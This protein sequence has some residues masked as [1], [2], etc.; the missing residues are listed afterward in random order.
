MSY[1]ELMNAL[2]SKKPQFTNFSLKDVK[3]VA[4]ALGN[5]ERS[6]PCV[7][8][9]GTNGKGSV[10]LKVAR[11][12]EMSGLKVGLFTSPHLFSYRERIEINRVM[13]TEEEII[14]RLVYLMS[15][16]EE[17][18]PS[19]SFFDISTFLAFS[20]FKEQK[21]DIA[22]IEAG[23]GGKVDTTNIITPLVSVIT[24][25]GNDHKDVLGGSIEQIAAHKAGIIKPSVPVVIG[26]FADFRV[27][28][29]AAK[30]NKSYVHTVKRAPGFYDWENQN[31]A[32]KTLEVLSNILP[33]NDE[34]IEQGLLI[35][36]LCRF[37]QIGGV[38]F[39]V[40]H[41]PDGFSKLTEALG[42]FFSNRKWAF[43]VGMVKEKDIHASLSILS[44]KASHLY[45]VEISSKRSA[46]PEK[47]GE[48]LLE[49]GVSAFTTCFSIEKA[50]D[51]ALSQEDLIVVCGSFY[52]MQEAR[53]FLFRKVGA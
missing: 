6:F 16:I 10:A 41:N 50:I 4:K 14:S 20:Y 27:I 24:S 44:K 11:A 53:S 22:V 25:V 17:I 35:R 21:I 36:P 12:L 23:I 31:I 42:T 1:N 5:P 13:I 47:M 9:A 2:F 7:H 29:Q 28:H 34:A 38:I 33:L 45:L 51:L 32:R 46:S 30:E 19:A 26:P 43:I 3:A 49:E 52:L 37:E 8:I 39:D 18:Y 15:L 40:A 48:I